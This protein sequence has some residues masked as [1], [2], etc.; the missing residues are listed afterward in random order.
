M[1][2]VVPSIDDSPRARRTVP[3]PCA[4]SHFRPSGR[5]R[6]MSSLDRAIAAID[7]IFAALDKQLKQAAEAAPAAATKPAAPSAAK[8]SAASKPAPSTEAGAARPKKEKKEKK[9]A[10]AAAEPAVVDPFQKADLR[11]R[12]LSLTA[13]SR[14]LHA[15]CMSR[16][17][18][19]PSGCMHVPG[20]GRPCALACGRW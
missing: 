2:D 13:C 5:L 15:P 3:L 7:D 9:K 8:P 6:T 12:A 10:P 19:A 20:E 18:G 1:P 11:V 14:A 4:P 17:R 16:F